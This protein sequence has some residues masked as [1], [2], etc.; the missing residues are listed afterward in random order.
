[1]QG[2]KKVPGGLEYLLNISVISLLLVFSVTEIRAGEPSWVRARGGLSWRAGWWDMA[3]LPLEGK[4]FWLVTSISNPYSINGLYDS[5]VGL[6]AVTGRTGIIASW[7]LLRH[8]IYRE[9]NLKIGFSHGLISGLLRPEVFAS[10]SGRRVSGY[11]YDT[12]PGFKGQLSSNI[13]DKINLSFR[14]RLKEGKGYWRPRKKLFVSIRHHRYALLFGR[15]FGGRYQDESR[16][17]IEVSCGK[18]AVLVSGYRLDTDEISAGIVLKK[19]RWFYS[20]CWSAHPVLGNTF[21][22]G[23]GRFW[24]R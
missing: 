16:I 15:G 20:V 12:V 4:H 6:S 3:L 9:D 2:G 17:G 10:I 24:K 11:Q 19:D 18:R 21:T 7:S 13:R 23:L 14:I 22:A 1:M 5:F 8:E